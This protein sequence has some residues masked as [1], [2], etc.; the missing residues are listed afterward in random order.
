MCQQWNEEKGTSKK[1][2]V[3][4]SSSPFAKSSK[5]DREREAGAQSSGK[6]LGR[7]NSIITVCFF[8][9]LRSSSSSSSCSSKFNKLLPS[10]SS[11]KNIIRHPSL[12]HFSSLSSLLFSSLL[13]FSLSISLIANY[14]PSHHQ[15]HHQ[16][17]HGRSAQYTKRHSRHLMEYGCRDMG[18]AHDKESIKL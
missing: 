4:Y 9:I 18:C 17:N 15:Y 5:E 3:Q 12:L 6:E 2:K 16:W 11:Y 13:Y 7:Q 14:N 10:I 8:F 1:R